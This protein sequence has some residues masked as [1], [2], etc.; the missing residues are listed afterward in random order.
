MSEKKTT[1]QPPRPE[2]VLPEVIRYLEHAGKLV[3]SSQLELGKLEHSKL[4][5]LS[6]LRNRMNNLLRYFRDQHGRIKS[7]N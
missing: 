2:D 4:G 7:R 1:T 6:K 3:A 5:E